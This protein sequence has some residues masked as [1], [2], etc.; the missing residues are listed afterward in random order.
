MN[1]ILMGAG[2]PTTIIG[3]LIAIWLTSWIWV[4]IKYT[5]YTDEVS[6]IR[7]RNMRNRSDISRNMG[8]TTNSRYT[9]NPN[10]KRTTQTTA[11]INKNNL[12]KG[13]LTTSD[14]ENAALKLPSSDFLFWLGIY[15]MISFCFFTYIAIYLF[16]IA[17]F[18]I[19]N[20]LVL[21]PVPYF[22]ILRLFILFG[23][24]IFMVFIIMPF[25]LRG[26][27]N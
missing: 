8:L 5:S 24:P 14:W 11:Y 21:L 25:I 1:S 26:R 13:G 7:R 10:T 20:R 12:L 15:Q 3:T 17:S 16:P 6:K 23:F 22:D 19:A 27:K 9:D 2:L 18:S 4:I